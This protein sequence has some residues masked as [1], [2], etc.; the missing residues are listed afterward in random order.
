MQEVAVRLDLQYDGKMSAIS[1]QMMF[2]LEICDCLLVS[3]TPLITSEPSKSRRRALPR[4]WDTCFQFAMVREPRTARES[5][6]ESPT[7]DKRA[8]NAFERSTPLERTVGG[9]LKAP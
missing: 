8:L 5:D 9:H 7:K 6:L 4:S 3:T 1:Q 2:H